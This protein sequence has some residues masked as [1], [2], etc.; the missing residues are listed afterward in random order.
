MLDSLRKFATTWPGKILG[1]FLLVGL[2]GFGITGVI[3]SIG[4]NTIARVGDKDISTRDF[5]RAYSTQINN[6][7]RQIGS[8]PTPEQAVAFGIPGNVLTQLSTEMALNTLAEQFSLGLSDEKLGEILALDPNFGGTLGAFD[9]NVFEQVLQRSG[10]TENEFFQIRREAAMRQQIALGMFSRIYVPETVAELARRFN[11]D[12]RILDYVIVSED[13]LLPIASPTDE[14]L[15]EFLEENQQRYRTPEKRRIRAIELTPEALAKTYEIDQSAIEAEYERTKDNLIRAETR[16]ISQLQLPTDAQVRWFEFG[17]ASGKS[18]NDLVAEA[19]LDAT[20]LGALS[21]EQITDEKL[22]EAAFS[23]EPGETAIVQGVQGKRAITVTS[24]QSGGQIPLG[25]VE[26]EI[27]QRL[28][29]ARAR[30]QYVDVLDQI[31]EQRAAFVDMDKIAE[32]FGL[33]LVE[34]TITQNGNELLESLDLNDEE[35]SRVAGTIF[36]TEIGGLTASI[37]MGANKTLWFDLLEVEE[38]RDQT[39][40]EVRGPLETAWL[41]EKRRAALAERADELVQQLED[42]I[43]FADMAVAN[44]LFP[45]TSQPASRAGDGSSIIDQTVAQAAYSGGVGY[46]GTALSGTGERVVFQVRSVIPGETELTP[47][48]LDQ[49][50]LGFRNDV[51]SDFANAL[52]DDAQV[53]VNQGVLNQVLGL[54]AGGSGFN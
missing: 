22:A 12:R 4:T 25:D 13:M 31:E 40:E 54:S 7:S 48:E 29:I 23:L 47:E 27:A 18:F 30:E 17:L 38:A 6:I 10:Y 42:G 46:A 34:T 5:Q 16:N 3:S 49:V 14:V 37:L 19:G 28:A 51:Y 15:T 53:R 35:V 11:A 2:A 20:E 39:L 8:T 41:W 50:R 26:D 44:G 43:P 32:A 33:E 21:R 52:R 9:R 36:Q 1:A 24:I 45:Q